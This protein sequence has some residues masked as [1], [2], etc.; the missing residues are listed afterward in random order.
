LPIYILPRTGAYKQSVPDVTIFVGDIMSTREASVSEEKPAR[1][2]ASPRGEGSPQQ[3]K[4]IDALMEKR[5]LHEQ[6]LRDLGEQIRASGKL[7]AVVFVD[8]SDSTSMKEESDP[9]VWLGSVYGFV[10]K[11]ELVAREGQGTVVKRI[12]DEVLVTFADVASSEAFIEALL[13]NPAL[14]A[15]RFKV[16]A[17]FGEVFHFR[18]EEHLPLDPYG[19]VVDR[20][21]RIAKLATAGAVLCSGYYE[22][23]VV[24]RGGYLLAGEQR[25]AGIRKPVEIFLRRGPSVVDPVAYLKPL[26]D[27]LNADEMRHRPS[28]HFVAR[29]FSPKDFEATRKG[30]GRPFLIRELLDVPHLGLT[31]RQFAEKCQSSKKA[32]LENIGYLVEWEGT[33]EE[34]RFADGSSPFI[35][36]KIV[37]KGEGGSPNVQAYLRLPPRMADGLKQHTVGDLLG[38]RGIIVEVEIDCPILDFVQL[39]AACKGKGEAVGS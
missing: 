3:H 37:D 8:L 12:G 23:E 4:S 6:E 18:F 22:K 24:P 26:L 39:R 9:D 28:Y 27:A 29:E 35:E 21:A 2:T 7:E 14:L 5:Q 16:T 25:L 32:R 13:T 1:T 34:S 20:C 36:V 38:F 17:D 11:V 30:H 15:Y 31:L 19:P 33:Y 10:R